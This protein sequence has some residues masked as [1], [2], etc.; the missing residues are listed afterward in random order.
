MFDQNCL[1]LHAANLPSR[2]FGTGS[3]FPRWRRRGR[4]QRCEIQILRPKFDATIRRHGPR[5]DEWQLIVRRHCQ[6][7]VFVTVQHLQNFG[8][9]QVKEHHISRLAAH[10]NVSR[11]CK[12]GHDGVFGIDKVFVS[13]LSRA[14]IGSADRDGPKTERAVQGS[15][16]QVLGIGRVF[17]GTNRWIAGGVDCFETLSGRQ[18]PDP[19][20]TIVR[21]TADRGA[22]SVERNRSD[23]IGMGR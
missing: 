10:D 18:V 3:L 19:N 6:H 16:Q 23:W 21:G 20:Q 13:V 14:A 12:V 11:C 9:L 4:C 5:R 1:S 8:R 7:G 22:V 15:R 2:L 17:D